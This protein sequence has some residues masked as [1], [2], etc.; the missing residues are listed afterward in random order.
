MR[1]TVDEKNTSLESDFVHNA[2][3]MLHSSAV[4]LCVCSQLASLIHFLHSSALLSNFCGSVVRALDPVS[5]EKR[6]DQFILVFYIYRDSR[7]RICL[8]K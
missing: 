8:V 5:C 2:R 7:H 4:E 1:R 6:F 3:W